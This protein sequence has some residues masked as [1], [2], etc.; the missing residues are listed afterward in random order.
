MIIFYGKNLLYESSY[1]I[2]AT[3]NNNKQQTYDE[4]KRNNSTIRRMGSLKSRNRENR[5][6]RQ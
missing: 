2:F 6:L 3:V 5:R 1:A 4:N